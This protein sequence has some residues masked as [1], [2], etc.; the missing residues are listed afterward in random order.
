MS[1]FSIQRVDVGEDDKSK[2][3]E[4]IR[5][6]DIDEREPEEA[7]DKPGADESENEAVG[8]DD[9]ATAVK[10]KQKVQDECDYD[11]AAVDEEKRD[12]SDDEVENE[13][14]LD[15]DSH[16]DG[17]GNEDETIEAGEF[18]QVYK[19]DKQHH[20]WC[21]LT[22]QLS[23]SYKNVDLS[24]A[25]KEVARKAVIMEVPNI[26]RAIT[27]NR[28][29]DIFLK[30]DGININVSVTFPRRLPI[31]YLPI[32]IPR[33]L[34]KLGNVQIHGDSESEPSVHQSNSCHGP[35]V[36]HRSCR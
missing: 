31:I 28:D 12:A 26:R 6:E 10:L 24:I 23:M 1:C 11:E 18:Q 13:L 9:D 20:L 5:D 4:T 3:T 35:N 15:D 22:F 33:F 36:R 25:L 34:L 16:E 14:K 7:T 17:D 2:K 8:E 27:Y 29:G 21:E 30:T 19:I 32:K